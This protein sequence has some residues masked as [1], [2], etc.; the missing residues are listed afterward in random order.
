[1][2]LFNVLQRWSLALADPR[3]VWIDPTAPTRNYAA[4]LVAD[5]ECW[6]QG[7]LP[8][9]RVVR[10]AGSVLGSFVRTERSRGYL[11]NLTAEDRERAVTR[12]SNEA[13]TLG[14]ALVYCALRPSTEWWDHL[15]EWQPALVAGLELGIFAVSRRSAEVVR[16]LIDRSVSEH[17]I[18][19][20]LEW[21]ATYT[22]DEHWAA[23]QEKDL[24]FAH[25]RLTK[26]GV[27]PRFG[28]TLEVSGEDASL[29]DSR[30][31]SLVRQALAY[32]KTD[33]AILEVGEQTRLS[34]KLGEPVRARTGQEIFSTATEV[35]LD[36]LAELERHGVSF[37]RVLVPVQQA[38]L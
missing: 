22:D 20:R 6:E 34:V 17:E 11:L 7:H 26:V 25:V 31:V 4:L 29:D 19:K 36:D 35:D 16:R 3:F 8:E 38:A 24:G 23:K 37:A 12:L 5:T 1:V 2:R 27:S 14:A 13:R 28:I 21:A 32:R 33:G 10:L 18:G 30:L 15:F 9:D